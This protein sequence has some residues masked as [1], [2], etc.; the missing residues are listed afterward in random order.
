MNSLVIMAGGASSRMKK[1]L[2]QTSLDATTKAIAL[3]VHKSLIPLGVSQ[4]LLL[5]HL[6]ENAQAAGYEKIY[7]ITAPENSTFKTVLSAYPSLFSNGNFQVHYAFQYPPTGHSKPLGTADAVLQ[8]MTQYPELEKNAF[9]LCNGDN[10]Y[11][12]KSLALLLKPHNAPHS[13]ISYDR[14]GLHF[15]E[16]RIARFA[17]LALD[18]ESYLTEIIEKPT[19]EQLAQF[20]DEKEKVYVSMNLFRFTGKLLKPYLEKCPIHPERKEKEL[21]VAVGQLVKQQ[22]KTIYGHKLTE[23]V[24]DLTAATDLSHFN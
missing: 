4:K 19:S 21:P 10:L 13:L 17:I 16:E 6:L 8:A 9:T 1:S 15:S 5:V 24:P 12:K 23:N 7:L 14:S 3:R 2:E 11:S 22:P 20:R 18:S